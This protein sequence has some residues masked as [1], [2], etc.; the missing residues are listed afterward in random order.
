MRSIGIG[1]NGMLVVCPTTIPSWRHCE[2]DSYQDGVTF[3]GIYKSHENFYIVSEV[4]QVDIQF[5]AVLLL[6]ENSGLAVLS[7]PFS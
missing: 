7:F 6:A 4:I 3:G 5:Y 1:I 2:K